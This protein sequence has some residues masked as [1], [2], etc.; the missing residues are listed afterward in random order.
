MATITHEPR[1]AET[2]GLPEHVGIG[3]LGAGF[4]GLGMAIR[5]EEAG[6]RDYL[7]CERDD[8]VGGTWWANTYPGCQCDIPSHLYSF[9]FALNPEWS[10]TYPKQ[11]EIRD[12]LRR[13]ADHAGV[14]DRIRLGVAATG[15]VI[16][17]D[18]RRRRAH[19]PAVVN[20]NPRGP[21]G[22]VQQRVEQGPVSHRIAAIFHTLG[23]A[24]G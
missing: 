24:E 13:V 15:A 4:A 9:S 17:R 22:R 10:R 14:R 3:I 5:L 8:E 2:G 6:I 1:N 16:V 18:E 12:Y 7:V 20:G 19:A 21:A 11:P 23:L